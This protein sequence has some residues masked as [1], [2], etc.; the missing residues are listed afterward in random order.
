MI[1]AKHC[2]LF[3]SLAV[4]ATQHL[5]FLDLKTECRS[6]APPDLEINDPL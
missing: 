5:M 2:P 4:C 6:C 3:G 1:A